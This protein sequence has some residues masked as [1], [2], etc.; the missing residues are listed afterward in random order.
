MEISF[1]PCNSE[2]SLCNSSRRI[3]KDIDKWRLISVFINLCPL[4]F[5]QI[6][7]SEG[8]TANPLY[9]YTP[10]CAW[11]LREHPID[12]QSRLQNAVHLFVPALFINIA[13]FVVQD[14]EAR[15]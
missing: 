1:S 13:T 6:E 15:K 3:L 12:R 14:A 10:I 11:R 2:I 4:V 9:H 5:L 7:P 8:R